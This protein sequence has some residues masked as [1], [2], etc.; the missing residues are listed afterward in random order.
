MD[1]RSDIRRRWW[2]AIFLA[3]ALLMVLAGQTIL[4]E[5]LRD[6]VFIVYWTACF[7]F[8]MLAIIV[9]FRDVSALQRRAREQQREL[10]ETTLKEVLREKEMKSRKEK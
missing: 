10:I 9:A 6:A 7:V 2:G 8:T 5:Y 4:R 1:N 3:T